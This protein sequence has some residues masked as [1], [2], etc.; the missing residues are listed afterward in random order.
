MRLIIYLK[1]L[2]LIWVITNISYA[3]LKN[4]KNIKGIAEAK[5]EIID[6]IKTGG[7]IILNRDD[8]FFYL[9]KK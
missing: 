3:H 4:F 5:S 8:E 9:F 1:Y 6:N 7:N 2:S